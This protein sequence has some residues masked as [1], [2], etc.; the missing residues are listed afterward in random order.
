MQIVRLRLALEDCHH[1]IHY[2][3]SIQKMFTTLIPTVYTTFTRVS[4][5][6]LAWQFSEIA[7]AV[8]AE[9]PPRVLHVSSGVVGEKSLL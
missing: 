6:L 8:L 7:N 9:T 5:T 4:I 2:P 1:K 3:S